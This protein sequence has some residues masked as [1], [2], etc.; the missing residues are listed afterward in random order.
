MEGHKEIVKRRMQTRLKPPAIFINDYPCTEGYDDA[1]KCT[2]PQL[3]IHGDNIQALDLRCVAGCQVHGDAST[4]ARA[5]ELFVRVQHFQ[6]W[7]CLVLG[8][9]DKTDPSGLGGWIGLYIKDQGVIY[10]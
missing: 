7:S 3:C 5:K 1:W 4:E 6:P 8:P 10:G 2:M 9:R